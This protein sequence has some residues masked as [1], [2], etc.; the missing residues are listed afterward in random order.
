M[1]KL[2]PCLGLAVA[3]V[4][5]ANSYGALIDSFE[6]GTVDPWHVETGIATLSIDATDGSDGTH[7]LLVTRINKGGWFQDWAWEFPPR[8]DI[9]FNSVLL[10]DIKVDPND[11]NGTFVQ[12]TPIFNTEFGGFLQGPDI[13]VTVDN[14]WHTYSWDYTLF[15]PGFVGLGGFFELNFAG[16]TN[17]GPKDL[18]Y[19]VDN[20]R[21]PLTIP[22]P[23]SLVLVS[24]S[25]LLLVSLKRRR[26]C[27]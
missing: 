22:E 8:A 23:A 26:S 2:I 6:D 9:E 17:N 14:E 24:V 16:N 15:K 7:S 5:S 25:G 21:L 20:V 12:T 4:F 1:M 13:L 11:I 19:R 3:L 18:I 27:L 10:W